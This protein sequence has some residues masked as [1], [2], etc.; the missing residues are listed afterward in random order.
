MAIIKFRA[1]FT[2]GSCFPR[3]CPIY[4]VTDSGSDIRCIECL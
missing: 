4:H 1:E 3:N 2:D